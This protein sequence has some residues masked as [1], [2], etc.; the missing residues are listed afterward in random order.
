MRAEIAKQFRLS[1][2]LLVYFLNEEIDQTQKLLC[3]IADQLEPV[4]R[5]LYALSNRQTPATGQGNHKGGCCST[6][7][8]ARPTM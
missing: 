2:K 4:Y 8:S 7:F 6:W 1:R 3:K 5:E